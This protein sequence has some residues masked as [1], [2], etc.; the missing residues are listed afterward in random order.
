MNRKCVY[1]IIRDKTLREN[2][3]IKQYRQVLRIK[4]KLDAI[5]FSKR[6]LN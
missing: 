5:L 3:S 1:K 2:L 6:E 4:S